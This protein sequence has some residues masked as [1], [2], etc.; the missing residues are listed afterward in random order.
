MG[1]QNLCFSYTIIFYVS[2]QKSGS[3]TWSSSA[4]LTRAIIL[5]RLWICFNCP[6]SI[7]YSATAYCY[8]Q[9][10][11]ATRRLLHPCKRPYAHC[12][13]LSFRVCKPTHTWRTISLVRNENICWRTFFPSAHS[14]M[15][16][17]KNITS[18]NV[19]FINSLLIVL[20]FPNISLSLSRTLNGKSKWRKKNSWASG[21]ARWIYAKLKF[22]E[23]LVLS[24]LGS[25][26]S[27]K[28]IIRKFPTTRHESGC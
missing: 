12:Q 6:L 13:K 8:E 15:L 22:C 26:C 16:T 28:F 1:A 24:M 7:L 10:H 17:K 18:R 11:K 9:C 19:V 27:W 5:D 4:L 20:K 2:Q 14:S 21:G 25:F 23:K 3:A